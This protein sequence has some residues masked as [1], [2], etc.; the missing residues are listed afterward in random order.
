MPPNKREKE[1]VPVPG[2]LHGE[3]MVFQPMTVLDISHGGSQV[4]TP[5][6]LQLDSL[7]DFRLSLGERSVVVKG[8]IA[9]CHVGELHDDGFVLYRTGIEFIE[10]SEHVRNA[11][12]AFVDALRT[13]RERPPIIDGEI[14][15]DL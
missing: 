4:E 9:H 13:V 8:R 12:T 5:F 15:D 6:P 3:V 2:M 10:P 14:A 11:I 7:H 1:R